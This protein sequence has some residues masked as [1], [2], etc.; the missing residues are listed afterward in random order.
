MLALTVFY[1][2]AMSGSRDTIWKT[3]DGGASWSKLPLPTPGVTPQITYTDL[4]ALD[5]NTVFVTG[6]GYPRQVVFKTT[7]GGQ[8]WTDISSNIGTLG[9]GTEFYRQFHDGDAEDAEGRG[10][11]RLCQIHQDSLYE[12]GRGTGTHVT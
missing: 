7:D 8:T 10:Q 2:D 9:I 3:T 12:L 1:T 5:A 4:Q 6:N 11:Y